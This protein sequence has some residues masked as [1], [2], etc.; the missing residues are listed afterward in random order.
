VA[1]L[2]NGHGRSVKQNIGLLHERKNRP[3][4]GIFAK[5]T[6]DYV[7]VSQC[8]LQRQTGV[9]RPLFRHGKIEGSLRRHVIES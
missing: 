8:L 4:S 6:A 9:K 5:D 2:I 3:D 7:A 1:R